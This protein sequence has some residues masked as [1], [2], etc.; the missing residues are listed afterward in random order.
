[1]RYEVISNHRSEYNRGYL[2]YDSLNQRV[3]SA[4]VYPG[5]WADF[6]EAQIVC[7]KLNYQN[8][9]PIRND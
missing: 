3:L 1:M 4:P 5:Y 2:I 6:Y 7:N 8:I 9:C